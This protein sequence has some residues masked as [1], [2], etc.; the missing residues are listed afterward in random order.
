MG[1]AAVSKNEFIMP[2]NA[3]AGDVV[4]LTKPLGTQLAVNAMQWLTSYKE[5]KYSKIAHIM[6]ESEVVRAFEKAQL[7]MGTLN[8]VAAHLMK[9]Y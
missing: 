7:E 8:V 2:N 4:I 3:A 6:S 1:I 9:K 5:E